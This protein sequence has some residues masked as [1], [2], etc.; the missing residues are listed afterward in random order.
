MR[1]SGFVYFLSHVISKLLLVASSVVMA[2]AAALAS[3]I[4]VLEVP[5]RFPYKCSQD[6]PLRHIFNI[7]AIR[8][9]QNV[10]KLVPRVQGLAIITVSL[11]YYIR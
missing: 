5:V 4:Q 8:Q 3:L 6:K 11:Y 1:N 9:S 10:R 2:T 7:C